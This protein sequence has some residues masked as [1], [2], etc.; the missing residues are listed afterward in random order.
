MTKPITRFEFLQGRFSGAERPLRPPWSPPEA[1][2]LESCNQCGD[3]IEACPTGILRH[4]RGRYP[5]V[6][7]GRG[8]CLL[9]GDCVD[10]CKTGALSR[11]AQKSPWSLIAAIDSESC[12]AFKAVECRSCQDPCETRA[13]VMQQRIGAVPVPRVDADLCNGC[14]ACYGVC[15][16]NA[17]EIHDP[18]ETAA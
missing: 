5:V 8:E 17:I 16:V 13:I 15:P 2:F 18:V 1:A 7:F 3:C 12:L 6:D 4:A 11:R 9:C 10:S 14:G